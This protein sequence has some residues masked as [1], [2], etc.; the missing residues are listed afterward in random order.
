MIG[1]EPVPESVPFF[2]GLLDVAA[3]TLSVIAPQTIRPPNKFSPGLMVFM[4]H[5]LRIVHDLRAADAVKE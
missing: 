1:S 4:V 2:N 5:D 3:R